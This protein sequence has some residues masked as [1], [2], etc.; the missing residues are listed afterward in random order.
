M[1]IKT[2]LTFTYVKKILKIQ[3]A[4]HLEIYWETYI[5][6]HVNMQNLKRDF[7]STH[8]LYFLPISHAHNKKIIN[9]KKYHLS[10]EEILKKHLVYPISR[11]YLFNQ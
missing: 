10:T 5:W 6:E 7:F 4:D 3:N 8:T 9:Q 1:A 11:F 2:H